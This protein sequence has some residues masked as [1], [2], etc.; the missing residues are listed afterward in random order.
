MAVPDTGRVPAAHSTLRRGDGEGLP[1]PAP[2]VSALLGNQGDFSAFNYFIF[3]RLPP[4]F[5]YPPLSFAASLPSN[6][7]HLSLRQQQ[8]LLYLPQSFLGPL[9]LRK[10]ERGKWSG[11][12]SWEER[13]PLGSLRVLRPAFVLLIHQGV[14]RRR[15]GQEQAALGG[16]SHSGPEVLRHTACAAIYI[17]DLSRSHQDDAETSLHPPVFSACLLSFSPRPPPPQLFFFFY[18]DII[19]VNQMLCAQLLA[20]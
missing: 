19:N 15:A 6:P 11:E 2:G 14:Y 12:Q 7:Q 4:H 17:W 5:I 10:G 9:L 8:H 13:V 16:R 20:S 3:H 18:P 1:S